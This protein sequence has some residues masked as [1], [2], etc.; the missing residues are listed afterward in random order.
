MGLDDSHLCSVL[1]PN[2]FHDDPQKSYAFRNLLISAVGNN[3]NK[4]KL[5]GDKWFMVTGF[6]QDHL[7]YIFLS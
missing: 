6:C 7:W 5:I 4:K 1:K 3:S 2:N